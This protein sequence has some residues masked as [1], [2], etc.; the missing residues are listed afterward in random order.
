MEIFLQDFDA[1]R[2][3]ASGRLFHTE[4]DD[5]SW[6]MFHG[7]S[8]FNAES[9]ECRGF[10]SRTENVS[11]EHLNRVAAIYEAMK[12]GGENGGGYAILKHFSR[13]H[14]LADC[15]RRLVFF[16][17]TSLRALLYATHDFS[18][19]EKL[20]ALRIAIKELESYLNQPDVC[21]RHEAKMSKNF[22]TL[23][24]L[25][26]HPSEIEA[27]KPVM[28]DLAWLHTELAS[29][30]DIRS[31]AEDAY[32]RHDHG[33]VYALR[34]SPSDTEGLSWHSSM[35]FEA[36]TPIPASKIVAKIAVPTDYVPNLF[37]DAGRK[38][39]SRMNSGL[40]AALAAQACQ[41]RS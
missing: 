14:D 31:L 36:I 7:T 33:V 2:V 9:I 24:R 26:A 8:G 27:A 12:W 41:T 15:G 37:A 30:A 35:G 1:N 16:A 39:L 28:V 18:G 25:N 13:D 17:E 19:G 34:M 29:L 11:R 22:Q 32:Q 38:F 5:D 10:L 4:I 21:E 40:L 6:V 20:R 3:T 23:I